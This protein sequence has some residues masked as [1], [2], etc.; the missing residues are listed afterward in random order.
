MQPEQILALLATLQAQSSD[1]ATSNNFGS[2]YLRGLHEGRK[3]AMELAMNLVR[4][5]A[6]MELPARAA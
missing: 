6:R 5:Y 2:D 4:I 3:D 1:A